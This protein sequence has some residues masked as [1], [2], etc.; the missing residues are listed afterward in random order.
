MK[1]N[2]Q[3]RSVTWGTPFRRTLES[4]Q[5]HEKPSTGKSVRANSSVC[6]TREVQKSG[7][8]ASANWQQRNRCALPF[9]CVTESPPNP[10]PCI[11][12]SFTTRAILALKKMRAGSE[13]ALAEL[14]EFAG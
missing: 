14:V 7:H 4:E 1:W 5:P 12:T 11:D 13:P 9:G 8:W 6:K 3:R 10:V 2:D